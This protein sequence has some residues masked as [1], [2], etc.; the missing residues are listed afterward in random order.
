M[1]RNPFEPI[2]DRRGRRK[3]FCTN[4]D[5]G[6]WS[7]THNKFG[8]CPECRDNDKEDR[9]KLWEDTRDE[10]LAQRKLDQEKKKHVGINELRKE[11]CALLYSGPDRNDGDNVMY[12]YD[13]KNM[14]TAALKVRAMLA[15]D[16]STNKKYYT[17][18]SKIGTEE[19]AYNEKDELDR[20]KKEQLAAKPRYKKISLW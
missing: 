11:Q 16:G 8:K 13:I 4:C 15:A 6:Y 2:Y 5:Q 20:L 19:S 17:L 7:R 10:R 18:Q 1:L 9:R 3:V 12:E 14:W